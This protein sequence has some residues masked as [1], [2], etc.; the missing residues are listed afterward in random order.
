MGS[1]HS[2]VYRELG[3]KKNCFESQALDRINIFLGTDLIRWAPLK[4]SHGIN[5]A[6]VGLSDSANLIISSCWPRGH[7]IWPALLTPWN[8][9]AAPT[10]AGDL[11]V[12]Y[13]AKEESKFRERNH[14]AKSF[15]YP[16]LPHAKWMLLL[17]NSQGKITDLRS[18]GVFFLLN[19][20]YRHM[21][22]EKY[23]LNTPQCASMQM[24][25]YWGMLAMRTIKINFIIKIH[26]SVCADK[27]DS[28]WCCHRG[29]YLPFLKKWLFCKGLKKKKVKTPS[30]DNLFLSMEVV[31]EARTSYVFA[32][33]SCKMEWHSTSRKQWQIRWDPTK[34]TKTTLEEKK[35]QQDL[36]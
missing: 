21:Y 2:W 19:I 11:P 30:P 15:Q 31:L 20:T 16:F 10:P 3:S 17:K 13:K 28:L 8:I 18:N 25:N 29:K 7:P 14:P 24:W 33:W 36:L 35:K 6:V 22:I 26:L 34:I 32:A 9:P 12:A 4:G 27:F 5:R 23:K 1:Q